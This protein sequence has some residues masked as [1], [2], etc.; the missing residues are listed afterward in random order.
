VSRL[1]RKLARLSYGCLRVP[2]EALVR[3]TVA[4]PLFA[5]HS[6]AFHLHI[7]VSQS[8]EEGFASHVWLKCGGPV[9]VG[10]TNTGYV[11]LL[12]WGAGI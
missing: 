9:L 6:H 2:A 7:G 10:G 1:L 12:A 4:Q 8:V 5:R 3:A 11:P